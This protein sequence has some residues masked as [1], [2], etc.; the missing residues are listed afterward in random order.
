MRKLAFF[1][2]AIVAVG[3]SVEPQQ[4]STEAIVPAVGDP[5]VTPA[6]VRAFETLQLESSRTWTW[7]QHE[8]FATP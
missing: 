1:A 3:C 5:G 2:L 4:A 6:Q 8:D 7:T